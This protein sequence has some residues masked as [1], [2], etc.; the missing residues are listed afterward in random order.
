V[1]PDLFTG[2]MLLSLFLLVEHHAA[3]AA[4]R[5]GAAVRRAGGLRDRST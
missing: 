4:V 5:T 1:Q 2:L 3:P